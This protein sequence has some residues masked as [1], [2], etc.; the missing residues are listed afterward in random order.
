MIVTK[1]DKKRA[2]MRRLEY[3]HPRAIPPRPVDPASVTHLLQCLGISIP[4]SMPAIHPPSPPLPT[5]APKKESQKPRRQVA[6][7]RA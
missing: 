5:P 3:R 7:C 2:V 1:S 4:P 6:T